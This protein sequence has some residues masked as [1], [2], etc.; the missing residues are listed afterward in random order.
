[1][2]LAQQVSAIFEAV[3]PRCIFATALQGA[4]LLPPRFEVEFLGFGPMNGE[5]HPLFAIVSSDATRTP[6]GFFMATGENGEALVSSEDKRAAWEAMYLN[7]AWRDRHAGT[8]LDIVNAAQGLRVFRFAAGDD[9]SGMASM[10]LL[11]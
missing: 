11:G 7:D 2:T 10:T 8:L 4:G 3:D 9:A 6:Q 5:H 1:M